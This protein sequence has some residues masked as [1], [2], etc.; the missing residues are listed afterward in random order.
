MTRMLDH[1]VIRRIKVRLRIWP[2]KTQRL[3]ANLMCQHLEWAREKIHSNRQTHPRIVLLTPCLRQLT[4]A[5]I[6]GRPPK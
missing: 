2:S 5:K 1:S 6:A 3:N 4:C